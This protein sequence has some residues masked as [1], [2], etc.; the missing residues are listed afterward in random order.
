[1]LPLSEIPTAIVEEI[2]SPQF[3]DRLGV[4][5]NGCNTSTGLAKWFVSNQVKL[6]KLEIKQARRNGETYKRPV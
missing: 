4:V 6:V 2:R 3:L 1:M 5:I